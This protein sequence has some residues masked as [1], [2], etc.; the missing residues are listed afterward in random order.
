M[1]AGEEIDALE[2]LGI[3]PVDFLVLPRV[4]ALTLMTPLL[5]MYAN[6]LGIFGGMVVSASVLEIPPSAYWIE[7]QSIID[8]SDIS[9]SLI[10]S[11]VFGMLDRGGRLPARAAGRT[12]RRRRGPGGDVGGGH[13]HPAPDRGRRR[14]RGVVQRSGNMNGNPGTAA[15]TPGRGTTMP[16]IE[17]Q[18]LECRYGDAVVLTGISFAVRAGELFFVIGGSGCGKTTLLRHLVGLMKPARG[19]VRYFGENFTDADLAARRNLL[20]TFGVLYQS[21]ALWSSMTLRENVALP[22]E[23]YTALNRR[24]R[25]EIVTLKLAQVGL[26]GYEDYFPAELSG[27][28][29]KRAGLARALALDPRI[30]FFDEPSAG[31]DP[32]TSR[33]LDELVLQIRDTLGTTMVIVSHELASIFTLADR[34]IMLDHDARGII[35]EG[36]PREL[37]AASGDP[38]VREFLTRGEEKV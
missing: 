16:A 36:R 29:R 23:Q 10:K 11:V 8:L 32:V 20:K 15:E 22:L 19:A 12:Q 4:I 17:V 7:T 26:A 21:A 34:V 6:C 13:E 30:V 18:D 33:K 24:E 28:M 5:T 9:V 14:V 1:K 25:D 2:T 3:A 37:A 35:A 27:G 38:R 31:L